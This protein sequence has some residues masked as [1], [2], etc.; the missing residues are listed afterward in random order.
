MRLSSKKAII[1][2]GSAGIGK[3]IS[4]LFASEGASVSIGDI[5]SNGGEEVVR[6]INDSGGQAFFFNTDIS[7]EHSVENFINNSA[8]AMGGVDILINNAAAFVFGSIE[9][10]EMQDWQK[11]LG[12]NVI[13]TANVV[14][15]C[16]PYLKSSAA[17]SIVNIASVSSFIAQPE[18]IPYNSSKGAL[19]QLTRCLALDLASDRIRVNAVCPGSIHTSATDRHAASVGLKTEELLSIASQGSFLKR[20][21]QPVEVAYAALFLASEEASFV[22]GAHLVVDGGATV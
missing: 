17:P 5:D 22:T 9:N 10:V 6:N 12:V 15:N 14:K 1:T 8:S 16:L 18:F 7:D 21:G 11:I 2:G 13:G 19:L 20:V 3:A 4:E